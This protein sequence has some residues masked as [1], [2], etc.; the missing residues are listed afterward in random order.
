VSALLSTAGAFLRRD[1]LV[2][3][4]YRVNFLLGIATTI[5]SLFFLMFIS[6]FVGPLAEDKLDGYGGEYFPFLVLGIAMQSF[7][8]TALN[9]ASR[10]IREGQVLGTLE[11][12]LVTRTGLPTILVCMPLYALLET[13]FHVLLYIGLGVF[14]FD[15]P[16]RFGNAPAALVIFFTTIFAFGSLGLVVAGLTVAFKRAE[17]IAKLIGGLCLFLGGVYYPLSILPEWLRGPA[18][19]LPITPALRG[20]RLALLSDTSGWGEIL[21]HLFSL[22]AFI[23]V[24]LPLGILFFRWSLRRAMRDGTLTQY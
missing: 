11:A 24:V 22:L 18:H 8:E 17:P 14:L 10:R 9:Q 5:A 21:P 20:L 3:V 7:L 19:L 15:M 12:L 16:I 2:Q 4:S 6:D 1:F 13:A 23:A